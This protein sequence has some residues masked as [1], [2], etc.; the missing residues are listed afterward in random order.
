MHLFSVS[1]EW[2]R[3][4][5]TTL[6]TDSGVVAEEKALPSSYNVV[7]NNSMRLVD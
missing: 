3:T 4:A 1:S 6:P 5:T 2:W 7:V